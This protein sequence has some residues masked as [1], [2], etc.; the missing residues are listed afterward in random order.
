MQ[1]LPGSQVESSMMSRIST[2]SQKFGQKYFMEGQR[3]SEA[4][5]LNRKSTDQLT[6]FQKHTRLIAFACPA[7]FWNI[8]WWRYFVQNDLFHLFTELSGGN[9]IP[10]Y[11]M[12]ITMVFGSMIAGATSEGGASVAFPV[13]TLGFAIPP[14]VARDFSFM[15]QSVGMTAAAF[16]VITMKVRMEMKALFYCTAGGI[17]GIV[18]GLEKVAPQLTPS[19][20]KM[21]FV[22]IWFAFAFSLYFLNRNHHRRVFEKIPD[23]EVDTLHLL[24]FDVQWKALVLI[25]TGFLGGVF[26]AMAGSGIDICSFAA[27]TLLFRVSEKI[28]TPTSVVLMAI[29]TCVGFVYRQFYMGGVEE[30]AWGFFATCIPVVVIGAPLG[31]LLGSH[32]HRLVLAGA[33]Y[34]TDTV[35]LVLALIVVQPWLGSDSGGKPDNSDPTHLTLASAAILV[36]GAISFKLVSLAGTKLLDIQEGRMLEQAQTKADEQVE[37]DEV[38]ESLQTETEQPLSVEAPAAEVVG[39]SSYSV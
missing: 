1:A 33:V 30:D 7:L 13:M 2:G 34:L 17:A 31:S 38:R 6:F 20:S 24:G 28:A 37:T 26:S 15:I 9:G 27:L 10:R 39:E 32:F 19:Y 3:L 12:T 36:A 25:G 22:V 5:E 23:F 8:L 21:Y 11:Y 16:T 14:P 18:F 35:Q 29:N 4:E